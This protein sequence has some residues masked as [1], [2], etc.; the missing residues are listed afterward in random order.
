MKFHF[1]SRD[2]QLCF[3]KKFG[4][5]LIIQS[6]TKRFSLARIF[7]LAIRFFCYKDKYTHRAASPLLY[8]PLLGVHRV[9]HVVYISRSDDCLSRRIYR[10]AYVHKQRT[11]VNSNGIAANGVAGSGNAESSM[12]HTQHRVSRFL[13]IARVHVGS[14]SDKMSPRNE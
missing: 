6:P 1:L 2:K 5:F 13:A 7:S 10:I 14:N 8:F 3:K 12:I 4:H 9:K 11:Y